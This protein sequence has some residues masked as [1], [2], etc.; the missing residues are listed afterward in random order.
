[1][2]HSQTMYGAS[3]FVEEAKQKYENV[4]KVLIDF[5]KQYTKLVHFDAQPDS[6]EMNYD[7]YKMYFIVPPNLYLEPS[8]VILFELI[9]LSSQTT[10]TDYVMGWGAFPL[11]NGDFEI[12]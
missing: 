12:N 5:G 8:N 6:D 2:M 9:W 7:G 3:K 4:E 10:S 1:L 11:V